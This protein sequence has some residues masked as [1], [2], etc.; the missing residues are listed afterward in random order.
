MPVPSCLIWDIH[1]NLVALLFAAAKAG[2]NRAANMAIIAI[3]TNNSIRVNARKH[4][5]A[6]A[7]RGGIDFKWTL[8]P[9]LI[10]FFFS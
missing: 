5:T 9:F 4:A 8:K 2:S 6:P 10:G 7:V 3:T 1:C